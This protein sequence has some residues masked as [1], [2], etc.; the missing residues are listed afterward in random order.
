MSQARIQA[1]RS[2]SPA[3]IGTWVAGARI[4]GY[5]SP[6]ASTPKTSVTPA[7]ASTRRIIMGLSDGPARRSEAQTPVVEGVR[8][9]RVVVGIPAAQHVRPPRPKK[10]LV[11]GGA[12]PTPARPL[13]VGEHR[14]R[15]VD[16]AVA[17]LADPQ[18]QV[19][20]VEGHAQALVEAAHLF[21]D[22]ATDH[23]AGRGDGAA[24][25]DEIGETRASRR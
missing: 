14:R 13:V 5:V 19:D 20:V 10:V 1:T 12:P 25:P 7:T 24:V 9:V 4:N 18:A 17:G 23:H 21:E 11:G 6:T 2:V 16:D 8:E 15:R 22:R 3:F